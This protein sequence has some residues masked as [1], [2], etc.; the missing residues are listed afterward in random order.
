[1]TCTAD[2]AM[3]LPKLTGSNNEVLHPD[4]AVRPIYQRMM[5]SL[6]QLGIGQLQRRWREAKDQTALDA[7]TFSLEPNQFR[8]VPTDWLPRFIPQEDWELISAGV[9][10]RQRALNKFLADLYCG[11][12]NLVPEEVVY[13][14]HYYDPEVKNFT[15]SQSVYAHIYG[16]DLVH[17]EDGNYVVLE[18]NL[19]IPSGISYQLKCLELGRRFLPEL[20]EGY[21]VLLYD[22]RSTYLDMFVSLSQRECPTSVILTDGRF[23]SAFFEHR[24]LSELLGIPL[25]EGSDLQVSKDGRVCARTQDGEFEVDVIYRRVEDLELFVPGLR[26]AYLQNKVVSVNALGTGVVDDKLVFLW[27]PDMIR[28]YLNEEPMLKQ[29][30]SYHL[31]SAA[32]RRF[33]LENMD[34]LVLKTREGYGGQ[35]VFIMPDLGPDER[36]SISRGMAGRPEAFVAQEMLDFSKHLVFDEVVGEFKERYID[37]RVYSVQNGRGEVSVIPGGLTRVS[38]PN[39][40]ITNNSSGGL[41][42]GTWVVQ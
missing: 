4:G 26:R 30:T 37:L 40:R 31:M 36:A 34:R 3:L 16:V 8:P 42:K 27:V 29:A 1:M 17:L 9:A 24:Y 39:T 33:V 20:L 11:Q 32:N 25:V 6:Q 7:F 22:I 35:G 41:C 21:D 14:A 12:Q 13:S 38:L 2:K 28:H 19:R 23:G 5:A 15:P 10:Q 18:D